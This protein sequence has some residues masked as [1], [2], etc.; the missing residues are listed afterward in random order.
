MSNASPPLG[1]APWTDLAVRS[2]EM[3]TDAAQV[4]GLRSW[5]MMMSAS[6]PTQADQTEMILMGQEKLDA[7]CE[8][9]MAMSA[10]AMRLGAST[11]AAW[12]DRWFAMTAASLAVM[13][14]RTPAEAMD[15]QIALG[16]ATIGQPLPGHDLPDGGA[17]IATAG[18]DVLHRRTR[19]NA[20]RLGGN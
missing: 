5:R 6:A 15:N 1:L 7:A 3:M 17:E 20:L 9:V 18:L 14:S 10:P 13:S 12:L 4:I 19:A 8:M 16:Q 2:G 11:S